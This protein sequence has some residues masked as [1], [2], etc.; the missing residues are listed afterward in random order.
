MSDSETIKVAEKSKNLEWIFQKKFHRILIIFLTFM[1]I[2][3]IWTPKEKLLKILFGDTLPSYDMLIE[4]REITAYEIAS[5]SLSQRIIE[6]IFTTCSQLQS[7]GLFESNT[8]GLESS[9]VFIPEHIPTPLI[10]EAANIHI[11][12]EDESI[13]VLRNQAREHLI[14]MIVSAAHEFVHSQGHNE[15]DAYGVEAALRF[16]IYEWV[17]NSVPSYAAYFN[18]A[19][20]Q[21]VPY[22][23][24]YSDEDSSLGAEAG[25]PVTTLT[26]SDFNIIVDLADSIVQRVNA[27]NRLA[28]MKA[29]KA[30]IMQDIYRYEGS[31]PGFV[32]SSQGKP[33]RLS[34]I[35]NPVA[36]EIEVDVENIEGITI[37]L[38][39]IS[40]TLSPG[41]TLDQFN[42]F[43]KENKNILEE[44]SISIINLYSPSRM[45][46]IIYHVSFNGDIRYTVVFNDKEE[47]ESVVA[48]LPESSIVFQNQG[49]IQGFDVVFNSDNFA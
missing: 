19:S 33:Y 40:F 6:D 27:I 48:I 32:I 25:M 18:T 35:I 39:D 10:R 42:N 13:I 21:T 30:H 22:N 1:L 45:E 36:E 23:D 31:T 14:E 12:D 46:N 15:R 7:L 5:S 41:L 17:N 24:L 2:N 4:G 3:G 34:E 9:V 44:N 8:V 16:A 26:E 29:E 47:L 49:K 37:P 28:H 38:A 11:H 43:A 20:V